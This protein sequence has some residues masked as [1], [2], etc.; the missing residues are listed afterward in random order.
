MTATAERHEFQAEVQ[1]LLDLLVHSLYSHKD[2]FLRELVSNASDALDKLRFA[3]LTDPKLQSDEEPHIRITQD[4]EERTLAISDNGIGMNRAELIENLGTIAHSGTTQFLKGMQKSKDEKGSVDLIGQFGVG[5]Y[6]SFMVA[7]KVTVVSRRAGEEKAYKW[8]STGSGEYTVEESERT[9]SGTTV[10]LHLRPVDEEDGL[11]DYAAEWVIKDIVK[12]HS[13][14]VGYPIKMEVERQEAPRDEEGKPREGA[15]PETVVTDETLNSMQA[16]WTRPKEDVTEEEYKEFYKHITHDWTDPLSHLAIR[17][18]GAVEARALLYIPSQAPIDLHYQEMS[19]RGLQLFI[20]RVFIMDECKDLMPRHLRFIKGVVDSDDL[21]LNVSREILQQDR[22]IVAIRKFLVKKV[23]EELARLKQHEVKTYRDFWAQFGPALKE[24]LLAM[25]QKRDPLLDLVLAY[26]TRNTEDV[27][28]LADYVLRM[29]DGQDAIYYLTG[30][31]LEAARQSPHLEVF[32]EKGYE[33]LLFTDRVDEVWLPNAPEFQEKPW[34]SV[35]RGSVEL[36]TED[37]RKQTSEALETQAKDFKDLTT[38]FQELLAEDIKEVRITNRLTSSP[39]CLVGEPQDMS[40]QMM[41]ILRQMGQDV[42]KVKRILEVNPEHPI[43]QKLQA[44][45][46]KDKGDTVVREF[47]A[48]LYGQALL[49]EG[50]Q[51]MD[52]AGFGKKLAEVLERG[53]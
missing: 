21:S 13:D 37:E 33:V 38:L 14:F 48:L 7:D 49:A 17:M 8:E 27:T 51:P 35:G 41:E 32:Q 36:G 44:R 25:D 11:Q 5:F 50:G 53:L 22:K 52:P 9:S 39:A 6:S 46:E 34:R 28:T 40:P 4:A 29:P 31:T 43:L 1:Q 2:I 26:S 18:E 3:S 10:M 20:K 45:F 15:T 30:P 23:T 19:Y 12:K 42:P 24:G 47:A 16:I